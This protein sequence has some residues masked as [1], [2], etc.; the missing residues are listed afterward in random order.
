MKVCVSQYKY[1]PPHPA[2]PSRGEECKGEGDCHVGLRTLA[3]TRGKGG[4]L[5]IHRQ[6][7]WLFGD[8]SFANTGG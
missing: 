2:S 5:L 1:Y 6:Q 4:V 3:M 7:Q 8:V